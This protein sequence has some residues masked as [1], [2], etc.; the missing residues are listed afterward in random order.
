MINYFNNEEHRNNVVH[1]ASLVNLA[2]TDGIPT[3]QEAKILERFAKKLSVSEGEVEDVWDNSEKYLI[4]PIK[5]RTQRLKYIFEFFLIIYA[6]NVV[7]EEE[8][9]V[10]HN[11]IMNLGFDSVET[12]KIVNKTIAFFERSINVKD[13]ENMVFGN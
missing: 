5:S 6:N 13:Y 11:Y 1:F 12:D 2:C 3:V 4:V 9:Q 7:D 10:V 8:Y